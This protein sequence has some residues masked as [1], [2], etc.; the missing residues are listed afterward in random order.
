MRQDYKVRIGII[1]TG[2]IVDRI[3]EAAKESPEIKIN[4]IYSRTYEKAARH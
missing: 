2:F 4:A 3:L 1:G